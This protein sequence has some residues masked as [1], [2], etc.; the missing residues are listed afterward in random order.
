MELE[1]DCRREP[2]RER[3][4]VPAWWISASTTI[5]SVSALRAAAMAAARFW[6]MFSLLT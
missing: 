6:A 2:E 3:L 5:C 4:P 1:L